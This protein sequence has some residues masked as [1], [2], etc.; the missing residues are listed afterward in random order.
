MPGIPSPGSPEASAFWISFWAQLYSS[1]LS[2]IV[3]GL[4]VGLAVWWV[5][6]KADQR[7]TR[8]DAAREFALLKEKLRIAV[9]QP[10]ILSISNAVDSIPPPA[11]AIHS[12]VSNHPIDYWH[13]LLKCH[14]AFLNEIKESQRAHRAFGKAAQRLDLALGQVIRLHNAARDVDAV[15]DRTYHSFSLGRLLDVSAETILPWINRTRRAL[16]S[17]EL[18]F[19]AVMADEEV[20]SC[21]D[22]YRCRREELISRIEKLKTLLKTAR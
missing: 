9:E 12:I 11:Q 1:A 17:L 5:Q 10:D 19:T 4:I 8:Q 20:T 21:A 7:R 22:D 2:S 14:R 3:T 18:A 6:L 13:S 15:N 16:D